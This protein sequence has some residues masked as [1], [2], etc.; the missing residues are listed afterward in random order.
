MKFDVGNQIGDYTLLARCGQGAY[1]VVFLAENIITGQKVALKVVATAG[2]NFEREL[3]GL[4]QYQQICRR[5]NLL[6]IYHVGAGDGFFYYTMDA[7]DP[8]DDT[9]YTPKTL[10]NILKAGEKLSV[11]EIR[12]MANELS[13]A[14]E[15]L[16]KRGMMH[17]D[18]KPENILWVDGLAVPGDIGLITDSGETPLAGTP[19]FMPP[20]VLA[21]LR[22]YEAK[23]DF[24]ALGKVLYC[25]LTGLPVSQYPSFPESSTL[26][27]AGEIIKLY[28]RLC[29]GEPIMRQ[30][31]QRSA[32]RI[33]FPV[34]IFCLLAVVFLAGRYWKSPARPAPEPESVPPIASATKPVHVL[35][36][37]EIAPKRESPSPDASAD[38]PLY[39]PSQEMLK[40][41][42]ELRKHY[43]ELETRM[44]AAMGE[45]SKE[46]S[47]EELADAEKYLALHPAH[48]MA[49]YPQA[50]AIDRKRQQAEEDFDRQHQDD[51]V[52]RYFRNQQK[53]TVCIANTRE[54]VVPRHY[55]IEEA[56]NK[57]RE[58]TRQQRALEAEILKKHQK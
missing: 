32:R 23:D 22:E 43:Q 2:R 37:P 26:T 56:R 25:A 55:S 52:W 16:H 29:A 42:P 11:A 39:V 17:R 34:G 45:A 54:H 7:A 10:A 1:G 15:V 6:Q 50:L 19:G 12:T 57:L 49:G 30:I 13:A 48:P 8:L 21:G 44:Y 47:A 46:V 14:L 38:D 4:R 20:E 5:T 41:L 33:I 27:G 53:I 51:P 40:L 9:D 35:P 3:K 18:I 36:A 31:R 28:S 58:L 24:Y